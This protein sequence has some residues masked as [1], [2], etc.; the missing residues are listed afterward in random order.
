M[1][2]YVIYPG[3][4]VFYSLTNSNQN[5]LQEPHS[6]LGQPTFSRKIIILTVRD[7]FKTHKLVR[8]S[9]NIRE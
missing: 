8:E 4:P 3:S 6:S 7:S 1:N 2:Y 5:L 9:L